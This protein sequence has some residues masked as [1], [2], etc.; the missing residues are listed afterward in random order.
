MPFMC[1]RPPALFRLFGRELG[2]ALCG[3]LTSTKYDPTTAFRYMPSMPSIPVS[4][5]PAESPPPI[6][7]AS[8]RAPVVQGPARRDHQTASAGPSGRKP[9]R[10]RCA[11]CTEVSRS[12]GC[13][14]S[15]GPESPD[16]DRIALRENGPN[17]VTPLPSRRP[18]QGQER[19]RLKGYVNSILLKR[20]VGADTRPGIVVSVAMSGE[21]MQWHV[22]LHIH[23]TVAIK[24]I[25]D[26]LGLAEPEDTKPPPAVDEVVRVPVDEE[27]SRARGTL[28]RAG[29]PWIPWIPLYRLSPEGASPSLRHAEESWEDASR[30]ALAPPLQGHG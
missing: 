24:Q 16:C 21:L 25:L 13:R 14:F 23:D 22:H 12:V 6:V 5:C 1:R 7:V 3:R 9:D 28:R 4:H 27:G 10:I 29:F 8:C 26:H 2:V 11:C 19:S 18:N 30:C 15:A 20:E 17:L